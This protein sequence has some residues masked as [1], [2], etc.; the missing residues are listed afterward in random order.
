MAYH[1]AAGVVGEH[2]LE[3]LSRQSRPIRNRHLAGVNRA[4]DADST[5]VVD[6]HP[7]RSR[8]GVEQGVEERPVGDGVGPVAHPLRLAVRRCHRAGVEVIPADDDRRLEVA[9]RHHLVEPEAETVALPVAEPADAGGQALELDLLAGHP[10]PARQRLV[11]RELVEHGPVG[12]RDV[13]RIARDRDPPEG[14][15]ARAEERADVRGD[16]AGEVEGAGAASELCLGA[17]GVAVVEDL[18]TAVEEADHGVHVGGHRVAGAG[19]EGHRVGEAQLRHLFHGG[20]AGD[21][22]EGVV[23]RCLVGDHIDLG[24]AREQL[25]HHVRR[26]AEDRDGERRATPLGLQRPVQGI[27]HRVGDDVE[28]AGLQSALDARGVD[29]DADRHPLVHG[30]RHRLGAAHAAEPGGESDGAGQR[31]PEALGGDRRKGFV[32]ALEDALGPDVDPRPRGHLAVHG[33]SERVQ[34]SK[35]GPVGPFRHQVRVGDQHPRRPLVGAE[36]A[37]RLARLHQQGLVVP[38]VAE[39]GHD[40]VERR[41]AAGRLAPTAVDDQLVGMLGDL[42][43]DVVHQHPHGGLLRPRLAGERCAA[44]SVHHA[45]TVHGPGHQEVLYLPVSPRRRPRGRAPSRRPAPP[46]RRGSPPA[47]G[48]SS[49]AR[50]PPA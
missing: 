35:L 7:G 1:P 16:E 37:D 14:A 47:R 44:R 12:G 43:V 34:P 24:P 4:P 48:R 5:A 15:L 40:G 8:R 39:A 21:V 27:V 33:Q 50:R 46:H 18:G 23:R 32:G 36:D 22:H 20:A 17:D 38:E 26:V 42:R 11:V 29:L 9:A 31:P 28:I 45:R 3:L 49:G 13:G 2:P 41:P 25:R 19:G 10:D 6:R 30:H